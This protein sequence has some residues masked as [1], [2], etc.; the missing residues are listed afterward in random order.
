MHSFPSIALEEGGDI[1]FG[2]FFE[3]RR[4]RQINNAP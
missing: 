4:A 1:V 3:R 2:T